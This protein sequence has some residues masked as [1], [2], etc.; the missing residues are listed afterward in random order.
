MPR[1]STPLLSRDAYS[2]LARILSDRDPAHPSAGDNVLG[3][4][5]LVR[6][7]VV[8]ATGEGP[9]EPALPPAR[10]AVSG[11][12]QA[13]ALTN[14]VE[15]GED[16]AAMNH[17][18]EVDVHGA[19]SMTHIDALD[20]FRWDGAPALIDDRGALARL[21][22]GLISRGVLLDVPGVLG[23]TP[24]PGHVITLADVHEVLDRQ[25][26]DVRKGD[27]LYVNL[28]RTSSRHS[29]V[30]LGAEPM[31]GL[32]I[33]CAEWLADVGPSVVVSDAG[34]DANPSEVDGLPV[35][36]HV[37]L[38][39]VLRIPLVDMARLDLLAETCRRL[40]RWEFLSVIAPLP[41]PSSSGSP[42]NPLA[43]F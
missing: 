40:G 23:R 24:P 10:A 14:W 33:E 32:S 4:I 29:H 2:D 3:A 37:M 21:S 18:F 7:G 26:I 12:P 41:I 5:G 25:Q 39:T 30:A 19:T 43:V 35:P 38:L 20:H 11:V 6:E 16:W 34:L 9:A 28:G 22:E 42:V 1:P 15:R 13:Y 27:A 36:W 8:V 31:A 17:R